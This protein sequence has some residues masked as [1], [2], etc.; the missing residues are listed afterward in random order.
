MLAERVRVADNYC[1]DAVQVKDLQKE[2]TTTA[3]GCSCYTFNAVQN[4]SFGVGIGECFA[5]LGVNGAGKSTT[6]KCLSQY[7][8]PTNGEIK[9]GGF[10]LRTDFESARKLIGYCPQ[11]NLI[12]EPLTIYDHVLYYS[13]I[14]GIPSSLRN[15]VC[16]SV[17]D[18]L[19]LTSQKYKVAGTLSGG[20]K[21]KLCVAIALIGNPPIILLDEPS[22]GMDP[23][24]RQFMWNLVASITKQK[25]S[26]IVLTTHSME[27]AEALSTKMGIMV[28]GGKF[29]CYGAPQYIRSRYGLGFVIELKITS[30]R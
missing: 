26:A 2:F 30:L 12:F 13:K 3:N 9:V 1:D 18:R 4:C 21:R 5:L 25:S 23:G 15:D 19:G 11:M 28:R 20:N 17:I 27:E 10:D 24:T 16:D 29:K 14:K 7:E 8:R 6:F 22:A